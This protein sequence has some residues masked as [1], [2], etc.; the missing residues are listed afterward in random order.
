MENRLRWPLQWRARN[1]GRRHQDLQAILPR[2]GEGRSERVLAIDI[3]LDLRAVEGGWRRRCDVKRRNRVTHLLGIG[4][5]S[6]LQG[7]LNDPALRIDRGCVV[8]GPRGLRSLA[9]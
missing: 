6:L 9:E 2:D 3:E 1:L 8:Y 5:G 4:R 7:L